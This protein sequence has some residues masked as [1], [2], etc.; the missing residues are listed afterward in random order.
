MPAQLGSEVEFTVVGGATIDHAAFTLAAPVAGASNPGTARTSPGGVAFNVARD[1]ARLGHRVRLVSRV[2]RDADGDMVLATARADG[3]DAAGMA[4]SARLPTATYRAAFDDAGGLIIGIADMAIFDEITPEAALAA[5]AAAPGRTVVVDANLPAPTLAALAEA[6]DRPVV[7]IAVSPAKAVRL[8]PVLPRIT[9]LFATRREAA[10][11]LGHSED[12]AT[13]TKD[14]AAAL[15]D[16]GVAHVVVTDSEKPIAAATVFEAHLFAPF[17]ADVR[18]VNGAGDAL[19]AGVLHGLASGRGFF[20]AILCG[21]AA[22]A[23]T[24]EED[25][26]VA[27]GLDAPAIEARTAKARIVA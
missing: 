5:M 20:D 8:V 12:P 3:I 9:L 27:A 21:L 13:P 25:G 24:V 10:A 22:A 17:P 7:A 11:L 14:L 15:V 26:T 23:I 1:L 19:A 16:A 18:S 4:L 2:G 6:T